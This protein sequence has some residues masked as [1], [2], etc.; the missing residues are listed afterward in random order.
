[1]AQKS[2]IEWTEN[3]WNP[4]TGCTKT[5]DGCVNC[6][7]F[8]LAER[9]R[10]MGNSK[11]DKGFE[12]TLHPQSLN[13]PLTWKKPSIIFVNSMSDIFHEQIPD[14]FI[15]EIFNVMNKAHHHIFQLLTKR[16]L[17]MMKIADKLT[18]GSNIMMGVT[19]ENAKYLR[20]I[21]A[22]RETPAITRFI[23]FEP[24]LAGIENPN[25]RDIHWAIVGGES[26]NAARP[27]K[28][29]WVLS[30]KD[31][32]EHSGTLFYFK[33]W[34]GRNKKKAGRELLGKTW[35]AVP[36]IMELNKLIA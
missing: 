30:I 23:S 6:Y 5:S 20:R 2:K 22:L 8:P 4:V 36:N 18:W 19:V 16:E 3:T 17:R 33:Q 13:D 26:G 25:L 9:L 32:C 7:A 24:L 31:A 27:M 35:D 1:M 14:E 34:G 29:E 28:E 15:I 12:V 21:E 11:Y 10:C